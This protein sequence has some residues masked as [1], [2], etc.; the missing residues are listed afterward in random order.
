[1]EIADLRAEI[2]AS[3]A[4]AAFDALVAGFLAVDGLSVAAHEQ[5]FL[6]SLR[7][8]RGGDYCFA[9][10]P[11]EDWVLAYIRKPEL[12]RGRLTADDVLATFADARL[13]RQGEIT[14]R[15]RDKA[16]AEHWL[17]MIRD[18]G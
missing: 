7:V 6:N 11:N 17:A 1:M 15:I 2:A 13:S 9:A 12:R 4:Q 8:H 16:T 18:A 14:L 5:G 3:D 10:V